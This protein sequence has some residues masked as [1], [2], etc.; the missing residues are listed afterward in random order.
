[1]PDKSVNE[2]SHLIKEKVWMG[3]FSFTLDIIQ[4]AETIFFSLK[5]LYGNQ[6]EDLFANSRVL[7]IS[8]SEQRGRIHAD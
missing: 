3:A 4:I 6:T 2:R 7:L 5:F 1:M 8:S